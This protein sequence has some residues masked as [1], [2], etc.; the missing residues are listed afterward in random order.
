MRERPIAF[1]P[2]LA[3]RLGS[4][5][6]ALIY[7]QLWFWGDKGDLDDGFI[8]KTV[9]EL[10][11]ETTIG[12]KGQRA[13]ITRLTE[14]GWIVQENRKGK[15]GRVRRYFKALMDI[16]LLLKKNDPLPREGIPPAEGGFPL[17]T[18][19]TTEISADAQEI[20]VYDEN[21]RQKPQPRND[22]STLSVF[23]LWGKYP[24]NWEMNTTIRAGAKN[25]YEER[26]LEQIKKALAFAADNR[27]NRHCP[28]VSDPWRLD[29][30][31]VAL[32]EFKSKNGL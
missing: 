28:S 22:T 14:L 12:E 5:N 13:A 30:N 9:E 1:Y 26:G 32:Y 19:T 11:E 20:V 16:D 6:D 24:K 17:Y 25:L 4:I 18:E 21:Q 27:D 7:Q 8:Y 2:Q 23:R 3:R 15:D 31:W 10:E 29:K